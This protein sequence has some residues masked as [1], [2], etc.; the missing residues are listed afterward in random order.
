MLKE[1]NEVCP[2]TTRRMIAAGALLVDVREAG[3]VRTLAFDVAD[4]VNIPLSEFEQRWGEVPMDREIVVVC[5]DGERS[6]KATYHL[7]YRG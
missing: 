2:S 3:E 4:I 5:E 7:Q 6:L 1:A